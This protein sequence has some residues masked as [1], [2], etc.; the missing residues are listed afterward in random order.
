M[1]TFQSSLV[2]DPTNAFTAAGFPLQDSDGQW[3]II[4]IHIRNNLKI[5]N[6]WKGS[7]KKWEKCHPEV[8]KPNTIE[9]YFIF[10]EV[11]F[12]MTSRPFLIKNREAIILG[13][14]NNIRCL[15]RLTRAIYT[16]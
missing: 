8:I 13:L 1:S 2:D 10:C 14:W 9:D 7:G 5:C 6:V 3:L 16:N 11:I 15:R 4:T 12:S